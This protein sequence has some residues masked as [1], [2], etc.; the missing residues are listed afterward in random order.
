MLG[1]ARSSVLC[2]RSILAPQ[3]PVAPQPM[4]R[5]PAL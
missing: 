2:S 4:G 5:Q 1:A 3:V